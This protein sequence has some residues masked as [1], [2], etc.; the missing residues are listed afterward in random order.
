M[1]AAPIIPVILAGGSGVRLW[2]LSRLDRP[3]QL[4]ALHG[5]G[6]LLQQTAKRVSDPDCFAPPVVVASASQA[7][8]VE[9]QLEAGE[10]P[11]RLLILEPEPRGTA[12]AVA[13]AAIASPDALLLV[14]PSDH[15]VGDEAAFRRAVAAARGPAEAG[16]LVCLG[17]EPDRAETGYGWIKRGEPLGTGAWAAA[18]FREKPER[19]AAEAMLAEGGWLWNAGIFLFRAGTLLAALEALAPDLLAC[20]RRAMEKASIEG[21]TLR[22]DAAAFA[23]IAAASL[24]R[25]VME[26]SSDVAVVPAAMGWSDLGSWAAIHAFGPADGSGNVLAGDVVAPGSRNSLVRSEGPTVVALGVEN[27]AIVATDR[28]VLV[29]PLDQTQRL[30]EALDALEARRG[31]E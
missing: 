23:A 16:K 7:A 24:D 10:T 19:A 4:V 21:E 29:V 17:A 11:P 8:A 26:R 25:A 28:A 9:D 12:A 2:P 15:V 27:L 5:G 1:S 18:A 20:A 30:R 6:T 13:L 3:K 22:P 31:R 14:L